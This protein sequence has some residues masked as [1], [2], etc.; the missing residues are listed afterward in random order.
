MLELK[1]KTPEGEK[2]FSTN[3]ITFGALEECM[4]LEGKSE[5]EAFAIIPEIMQMIFPEIT[6][7]DVKYIGFFQLQK[8]LNE[9]IKKIMLPIDNSIKN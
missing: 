7:E 2:T 1:I 5:K 4:K 8:L 9:D 6:R 3:D